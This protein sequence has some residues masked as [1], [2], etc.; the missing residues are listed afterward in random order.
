M[1]NR[2][3]ASSRIINSWFEPWYIYQSSAPFLKFR[4][5]KID[6]LLELI[7]SIEFAVSPPIETRPLS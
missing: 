7:V 2:S 4:P 5:P 1:C 3:V 6:V